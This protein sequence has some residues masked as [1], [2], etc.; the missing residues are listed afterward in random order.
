LGSAAGGILQ[1]QPTLLL[2]LPFSPPGVLAVAM[3][4]FC[5]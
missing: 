1:Q 4:F 2:L 5:L 3:E